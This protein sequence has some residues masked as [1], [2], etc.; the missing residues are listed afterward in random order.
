ME[1][2]NILLMIIAVLNLTTAILWMFMRKDVRQLEITMN[3]KMDEHIKA[4]QLAAHAK[5]VLQ[6]KQSSAAQELEEIKVAVVDVAKG[7]ASEAKR[8]KERK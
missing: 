4:V 8:A 2:S 5:G 3:S 6:E 1:L 7:E